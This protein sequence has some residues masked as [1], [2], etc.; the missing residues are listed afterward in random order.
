VPHHAAGQYV[1]SYD[2]EYHLPDGSYDGGA[3]VCT[4]L[5]EEATLFEFIDAVL[6]LR[7]GPS[8]FC[9]RLR[10]DGEPNRPLTA[11]DAK[12]ATRVAAPEP[13]VY[14]LC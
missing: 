3:L 4:P 8:C 2:P 9:H 12:V 7:A 11:F 1:V 6:L 10:A 13:D 14:R 5:M